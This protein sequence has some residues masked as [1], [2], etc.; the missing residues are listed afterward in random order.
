[1]VERFSSLTLLTSYH[2]IIELFFMLIDRVSTIN[3]LALALFL[4]I[5]FI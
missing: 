2:H 5:F 1:M 3:E 4:S